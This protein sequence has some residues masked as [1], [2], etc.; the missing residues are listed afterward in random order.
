[1]N[2]AILNLIHVQNLI[3]FLVCH[4]VHQEKT[5]S[6]D[7]MEVIIIIMVTD[8]KMKIVLHLVTQDV[9]NNASDFRCCVG[10]LLKN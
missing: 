6:K 9:I 4:I 10:L 1:M 3:F 5:I 8:H 7:L 2:S